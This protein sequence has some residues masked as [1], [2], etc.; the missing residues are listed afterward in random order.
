[1]HFSKGFAPGCQRRGIWAKNH[2]FVADAARL[3]RDVTKR[4]EEEAEHR[5]IVRDHGFQLGDRVDHVRDA[6]VRPLKERVGGAL[7]QAEFGEERVVVR[8]AELGEVENR[9]AMAFPQ[10]MTGSLPWLLAPTEN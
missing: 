9:P 7:P 4:A 6:I 3:N 5:L 2:C 10:I 1:M 8:R